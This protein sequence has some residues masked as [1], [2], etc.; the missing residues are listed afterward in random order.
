MTAV[1]PMTSFIDSNDIYYTNEAYDAN[2]T[3]D[4]NGCNGL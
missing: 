4:Y 3:N 2:D 1:T